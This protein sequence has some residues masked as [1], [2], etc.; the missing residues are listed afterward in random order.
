MN[1]P[2]SR[3]CRCARAATTGSSVEAVAAQLL[4]DHPDL[5]GLYN[6][7]AG[8]PRHRRGAGRMR[9]AS[10]RSSSSPMNSPTT[11]RRALIDGTIDIII[12]QDAGHEVQKRHPRADVEGRQDAASSRRWSASASISSFA[13]TSPEADA[14]VSRSRF[15]HILGEGRPDRRQAEDHR[16]GSRAAQG[17]AAAARLVGAEPGRLV[18]GLQQ[19][20][21]GAGQ[22]EAQGDRRRRGH[23]A[24]GPAA[25]RDAA[26]CR[27]ARCCA[28]ASC[29]TMRAPSRECEEI[30]GA[31]AA[32]PWRSPAIFRWPASPRRSSCG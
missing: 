11:S 18:E 4:A 5:I 2:T 8:T 28:P 21:E 1:I 25:W 9:A 3:C 24:F 12:N 30:D 22:D 13:T 10:T 32:A 17:V 31:R 15:R 14:H 19:R 26:R 27:A 29:G 6:V 7:G 20:G 16:H 23:R